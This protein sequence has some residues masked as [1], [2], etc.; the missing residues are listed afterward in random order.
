MRY[1]LIVVLGWLP[2]LAA[3]V[4]FDDSTRS[5]P[6]GRVMHVFEARDGNASIAQVSASSF[7][8]HFRPHQADVL[9]AG[10]STS[11]FWIRLD[12]RYTAK[13]SAGPRSWLLELAY[14]PLDHLELYLPDSAG[15]FSLAQRTGDALPYASRQIKQNNYLFE[16]P[17]VPGQST[18]AYLRLH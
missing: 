9:N 7:S 17:F 13:P 14:P 16:L 12:L 4:D 3:A 11:V 15:G 6:L 2:L 1:L 5:L 10:Y 18:T 8:E